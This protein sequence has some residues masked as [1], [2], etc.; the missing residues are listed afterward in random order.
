MVGQA[1]VAVKHGCNQG[2][3]GTKWPWSRQALVLAVQYSLLGQSAQTRLWA[4]HSK[5]RSLAWSAWTGGTGPP[6]PH[7]PNSK[8]HKPDA[9]WGSKSAQTPVKHA[10]QQL[11]GICRLW[12]WRG[13]PQRQGTPR[14]AASTPCGEQLRPRSPQPR[15]TCTGSI[16]A[17]TETTLC[18]MGCISRM[19]PPSGDWIPPGWPLVPSM[20]MQ[21]TSAGKQGVCSTWQFLCWVTA[22]R[23]AAC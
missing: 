1:R 23:W 21:A 18:M 15:R 14:G 22:S 9:H 2:L 20:A 8:Q 13:R 7:C 5:P 6:E 4:Q 11:S 12:S 16:A 17:V 3:A 10:N 19:W